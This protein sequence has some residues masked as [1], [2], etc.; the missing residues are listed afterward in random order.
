MKFKIRRDRLHA[1]DIWH[2]RSLTMV[3]FLIRWAL[4]KWSKRLAEKYDQKFS[5]VWGNHDGLV[6][7]HSS[8][9]ICI[10]EALTKGNVETTLGNY[11]KQMNKNKCRVRV[12]RPMGATLHDEIWVSYNWLNKVKGAPYN[13]LAYP[14]LIWKSLISDWSNS[15]FVW[16]RNIGNKVA[17]QEWKHWCTEGAAF[18]WDSFG[19]PN[20]DV[21]QTENSTPMTVEQIAGE[22][23]RKPEKR[24]SLANVTE[25]VI[26]RIVS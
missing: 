20:K 19:M 13:F 1:G 21:F 16:M 24:I 2:V 15:R 11:E 14:R 5:P 17:G 26:E 12:Y 4:S 3:G 22:V 8:R 6:I 23:P 25:L 7:V 18:A 10:G 9:A